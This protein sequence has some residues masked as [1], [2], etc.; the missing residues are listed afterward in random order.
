MEIKYAHLLGR[1]FDHGVTDCYS[2]VRDFYKDNFEVD[3]TDYARPDDWW[4][5][6]QDLYVDNFEKE[7][8][9]TINCNP[10]DYRVGDC[11]LISIP[12]P[13]APKGVTPSN[14]VAIYVGDNMVIHH[15]LGRESRRVPY[16]GMLRN[17]TTH[18][19]RHKHVGELMRPKQTDI[20][21]MDVLPSNKRRL[22]QNVT[23]NTE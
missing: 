11:F 4:I 12:D 23:K 18:V 6:G 14:H 19:V 16:K 22:I 9:Y 10:R 5:S 8:F 3:L 7:G 1:K 20:D 13:R 21:I 2:L 17:F 15:L